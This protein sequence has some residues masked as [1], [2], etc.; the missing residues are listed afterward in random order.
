MR[1]TT[2]I[3]SSVLGC[4]AVAAAWL[5]VTSQSST[6]DFGFSQT[7][8][9]PAIADSFTVELGKIQLCQGYDTNDSGSVISPS[10]VAGANNGQFG[11]VAPSTPTACRQDPFKASINLLPAVM[12]PKQNGGTVRAYP[13]SPWRMASTSAPTVDLPWESIG[14]AS[15]MN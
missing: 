4:F 11:F 3:K 1:L 12:E 10:I 6:S 2:S 9:T 15:M 13:G 7:Q 14:Y 8:T 5:S